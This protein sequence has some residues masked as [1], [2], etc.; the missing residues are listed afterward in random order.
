M[1]WQVVNIEYETNNFD[2]EPTF[3]ECLEYVE[4]DPCED[5]RQSKKQKVPCLPAPLLTKAPFLDGIIAK[6]VYMWWFTEQQSPAWSF[7]GALFE[8]TCCKIVSKHA[9]ICYRL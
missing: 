9:P 5:S 7:A 3:S 2:L 8:G 4:G 6:L 1:C